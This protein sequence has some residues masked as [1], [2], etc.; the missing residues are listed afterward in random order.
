MQQLP[1]HFT[2]LKSDDLSHEDRM[3][4]TVIPEQSDLDI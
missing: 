4:K 1:M 3:G 2:D